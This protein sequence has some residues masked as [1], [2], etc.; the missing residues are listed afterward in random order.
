MQTCYLT[1]TSTTDGE[2]RSFFLEGEWLSAKDSAKIC[3]RDDEA[4]VTLFVQGER[5]EIERRGDYTFRLPLERG[6]ATVGSLGIGDSEGELR[7]YTHKIQHSVRGNSLL[8]LLEYD[9]LL[10]EETQKMK[11]RLLASSKKGD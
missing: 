11:L 1:I 4:A 10:G 7:L 5:A 9:M 6:S 3:Y 8:L 2:E